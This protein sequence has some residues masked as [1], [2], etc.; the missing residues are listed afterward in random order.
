M[1][2]EAQNLPCDIERRDRKTASVC[3][4]R[5]GRISVIVPQSFTDE[6]IERLIASK[7][8]WIHKRLA[9]WRSMNAKQ[10]EREFVNGEGFLYL[11]RSYRLKLIEGQG[12]SLLLKNGF[13]CLRANA[14]GEPTED[15]RDAFKRFYREKGGKQI[16]ERVQYFQRQLGVEPPPVRVMELRYRWAS[17]SSRRLNFHWKCMMAPPTVLDYIIA[18]ELA[19]LRHSQH[20]EAFWNEL[21]KLIP[22]YR[23]RHAWLRWHG[24]SLAL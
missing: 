23:E 9:E 5:D 17:C 1:S 18:H 3:L 16:P 10:V 20:T 19:H 12:R 2:T 11:G 13:F 15:P 24:A 22:D 6:Q 7:R 21:D 14:R 8:Y 4:E